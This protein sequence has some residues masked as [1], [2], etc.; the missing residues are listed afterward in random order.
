MSYLFD[1]CVTITLFQL[2][3]T[4]IKGRDAIWTTAHFLPST[5]SP[6]CTSTAV[7]DAILITKTTW[8]QSILFVAWISSGS[9]RAAQ[10]QQL[11]QS[12]ME[13]GRVGWEAGVPRLPW[14][15]GAPCCKRSSLPAAGM[16][17]RG[18]SPAVSET[19]LQGKIQHIC[20]LYINSQWWPSA[21]WGSNS[22]SEALVKKWQFFPCAEH[23]Y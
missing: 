23:R 15:L 10:R 21:G 4:F 8:I 19:A 16:G 12:C 3:S 7:P 13:G 5:C 20:G 2:H 22:L 14:Q 1:D 11:L 6:D 9:R 18:D 17:S